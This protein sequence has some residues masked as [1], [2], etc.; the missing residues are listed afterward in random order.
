MAP[1][2]ERGAVKVILAEWITSRILLVSGK[3]S[4][5]AALVLLQRTGYQAYSWAGDPVSLSALVDPKTEVGN[6]FLAH[7]SVPLSSW[8]QARPRG[9]LATWNKLIKCNDPS[10]TKWWRG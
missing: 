6:L 3:E 8:M 5:A 10:T 7:S 1:L 2:L 4:L 9:L